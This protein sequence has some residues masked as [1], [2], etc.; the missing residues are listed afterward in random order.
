LTDK[1]KVG[2]VGCGGISSYH[3]ESL[4]KN[5]HVNLVSF[6]DI[7]LKRAKTTAKKFGGVKATAFS[8]AEHMFKETNLDAAYFCL[9]PFAHGAEMEA[10][11][12]EIPFFVEKPVGL[13]IN[14]SEDISAAVTKKQLITSVGYMSRYRQGTQKVREI[15]KDDPP[16]LVLGGWIS[17]G[18]SGPKP[19]VPLHWTQLK[20]KSGGQFHEQVT[21]LKKIYIQAIILRMQV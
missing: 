13:Y 7:N 10:V 15:L 11:N 14:Q 8:N 6:C 17:G 2:F 4:A 9:P 21:H 18:G 19:D 20:E 16:V 12:R 3:L 1:I 5:P